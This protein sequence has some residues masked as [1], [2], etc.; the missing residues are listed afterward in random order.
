MQLSPIWQNSAAKRGLYVFQNGC[1]GTTLIFTS[2]YKCSTYR[3]LYIFEEE[4]SVDG[5][6]T[7]FHVTIFLLLQE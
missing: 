2:T 6:R 3:S 1:Y 5:E 7:V 4:D